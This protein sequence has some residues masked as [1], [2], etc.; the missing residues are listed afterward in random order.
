[1]SQVLGAFGLL[2]FTMLRSIL[3][4]RVVKLMNRLFLVAVNLGYLIN[5]YGG[6]TAYLCTFIQGQLISP[7]QPTV[8]S[9]NLH[10]VVP[11]SD[12]RRDVNNIRILLECYAVYNGNT[13]PTLRGNL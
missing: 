2:D 3:D 7:A 4:W 8:I 11:D 5:G 12:Y 6:T 1:M 13:L 9:A 10:F